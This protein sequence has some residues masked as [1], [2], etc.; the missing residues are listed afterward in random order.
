[1]TDQ[2]WESIDV[3]HCSTSG[4]GGD[5]EGGDA[6]RSRSFR[7]ALDVRKRKP[8]L[9]LERKVF[10]AGDDKSSSS[11]KGS[12]AGAT[13]GATATSTA[14]SAPPL[15]AMSKVLQ[16]TDSLRLLG[17]VLSLLRLTLDLLDGTGRGKYGSSSSDPS[18]ALFRRLCSLLDFLEDVREKRRALLAAGGVKGGGGGGEGREGGAGVG[19]GGG[20]FG[21]SQRLSGVSG[22]GVGDGTDYAAASRM[23]KTLATQDAVGITGT[24]VSVMRVLTLLLGHELDRQLDKVLWLAQKYDEDENA[25]RLRFDATV[26]KIFA[27]F[28]GEDIWSL[29]HSSGA[30]LLAGPVGKMTSHNLSRTLLRLAAA[31][32]ESGRNGGAT[33][34]ARSFALLFRISDQGNQLA[35]E[36]RKVTQLSGHAA[37]DTHRRLTRAVAALR[38]FS[39]RRAGRPA[40]VPSS[41]SSG[42]GGG[43]NGSDCGLVGRDGSYAAVGGPPVPP[44]PPPPSASRQ[45]GPRATNTT[46]ESGSVPTGVTTSSPAAAAGAAREERAPGATPGSPRVGA[47]AAAAADDSRDLLADST[48]SAS[49]ARNEDVEFTPL[50]TLQSPLL[51]TDSSSGGGSTSSTSDP[52]E[53]RQSTAA[54][55]PALSSVSG[56]G[57]ASAADGGGGVYNSGSSGS[58]DVSPIIE[59]WAAAEAAARA[60]KAAERARSAAEAAAMSAAT[61]A[62]VAA[63][64]VVLAEHNRIAEALE[65]IRGALLAGQEDA[66][67]A[68]AEVERVAA[69]VGLAPALL[70]SLRAL[71]RR[72]DDG[73][74]GGGGGR[75]SGLRLAKE[76]MELLRLLVKAGP[77]SDLRRLLFSNFSFL[78]SFLELDATA[79]DA[80]SPSHQT[81]SSPPATTQSRDTDAVGVG[82]GA[83]RSGGRRLYFASPVA[84]LM[85]AVIE[86]DYVL[87]TSISDDHL[88]HLAIAATR[89]READILRLLQ[90]LVTCNGTPIQNMQRRV[91]VSLLRELSRTDFHAAF[92]WEDLR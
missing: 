33:L 74:D 7:G 16:L 85:G 40:S 81:P 56:Y 41:S 9:K 84:R 83:G 39:R 63:E 8:S 6:V 21:S 42:G 30:G 72:D 48:A 53:E 13:A 68:G 12:G 70:R 51:A 73:G 20:M 78:L 5:Q 34:T 23:L 45:G 1:M 89:S 90:K 26:D 66:A 22:G 11:V 62:S 2:P 35:R 77:N 46:E 31:G 38:A 55:A 47:P 15:S 67:G 27:E 44:L 71:R 65:E 58:S 87:V 57:T 79:A 19:G 54:G 80:P 82:R 18:S 50:A 43:G 32:Q 91:L 14:T 24:E 17:S 28:N 29:V 10:S 75:S 69:G 3:K 4:G 59:A 36:A 61:S 88:A 25:F 60:T 64:G 92:G 76:V 52:S 86:E 37:A 49:A